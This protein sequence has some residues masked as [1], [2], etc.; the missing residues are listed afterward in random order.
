[1]RALADHSRSNSL[2]AE[3]PHAASALYDPNLLARFAVEDLHEASQDRFHLIDLSLPAGNDLTAKFL[4][5]RILDWR[6]LTH[7]NSPRVM[8]NHGPQEAFVANSDLLPNPQ[9]K[10]PERDN[11]DGNDHDISI[12]VHPIN[13]SLMRT[14]EAV[15]NPAM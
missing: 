10:H 8:W 3:R 15:I 12:P 4:Y 2:L 5:F 6:P 7:E 13:A 9:K 14:I 11:G 1:V